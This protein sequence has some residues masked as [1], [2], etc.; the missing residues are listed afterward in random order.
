[1]L[2]FK[3]LTLLVLI[4]ISTINIQAQQNKIEI[5]GVLQDDTQMAIPY[6]AVSIPAKNIGTTSTEEGRFH[7]SL[8]QSNLQDT[9]V[10]SSMGF[11]TYKIKIEDYIKQK[12]IT[13]VLEEDVNELETVEIINAKEY[14]YETLK[15]QKNTFVSGSNQ[16]DLLYRRTCV[17]QNISKFFVE[18]YM[19]MIYKGPRSFVR[20]MQV[21]ESRKSAGF[22][23]VKRE[24]W[25]HAAVYMMDLNPLK[26]PYTPI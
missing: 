4:F 5:E 13:I 23:I 1:M 8:E 3:K 11:K 17:E 18:Q 10:I 20:N 21:N 12:I 7:L 26:D 25:N 22:Q 14:V 2:L 24:Q 6:V 9:L 16:L 19:S 15:Q